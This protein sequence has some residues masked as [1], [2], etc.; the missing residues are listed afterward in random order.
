MRRKLLFLL[1]P[2]FHLFAQ[3]EFE[4]PRGIIAKD[5]VAVVRERIENDPYKTW[6]QKIDSTS[7]EAER[8]LD[9]TDPYQTTFLAQ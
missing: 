4:H 1:I 3:P 7:L 6:F 9:S 5:E 2:S 8:T